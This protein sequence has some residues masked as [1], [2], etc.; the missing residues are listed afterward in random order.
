MSWLYELRLINLFSFYLTLLFCIST[1]LRWHQYRAFL[2]L[3]RAFPARWPNL[4]KLVR[5]HTN[6]FLTWGT[7]MPLLLVFALLVTNTLASRLVWPEA[8]AFKFSDLFDLWPAWPVLFITGSAML[9]VDVYG[10]YSVGELDKEALEPYFDQAEH[11]LQTWKAPVVRV[12]TLGY[13][14]PR[15]MVATEVR[16]ALESA[17]ELINTALWWMVMQTGLRI[18]FGLS[19]WGTWALQDQLRAFLSS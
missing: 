2:S 18:A 4:L 17:S 15:Q 13:I 14:S 7:V 16:S 10:T 19:L 1:F 9:G 8:N 3:V 6:I 11:W 12:L 5:Q